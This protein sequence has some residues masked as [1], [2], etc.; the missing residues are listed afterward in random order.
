MGV[1][2]LNSEITEEHLETLREASQQW[3]YGYAYESSDYLKLMEAM[4]FFEH[5]KQEQRNKLIKEGK[6]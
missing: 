4:Q 6:L 1:I 5:I 3:F 2:K